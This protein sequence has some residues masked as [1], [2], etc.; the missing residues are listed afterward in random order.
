MNNLIQL[1]KAAFLS[2]FAIG[3]TKK[4]KRNFVTTISFVGVLLFVISFVFNYVYS[5]LFSM[6]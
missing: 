2:N 6:D 4:Q 5:M 3:Q 1:T